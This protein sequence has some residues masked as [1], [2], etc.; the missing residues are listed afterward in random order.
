M[1]RFKAMGNI[2]ILVIL[3]SFNERENIAEMITHIQKQPLQP[4][5]LVVD[6]NSPDKTADIV[7]SLLNPTVHLIVRQNGKGGR[8]GAVRAGFEWALKQ[9]TKYDVIFEMDSDLSHNPDEIPLAMELIKPYVSDPVPTM[10]IGSRYL[11]DSSITGW[12]QHRRFF[13]RLANAWARF[14]LAKKVSDF[15]NGF[16]AYNSAAVKVILNHAPLNTGFIYLSECLS[17]IDCQGGRIL[18][19]ASH[20]Q[21]RKH[22]KSSADFTEVKN[23]FFGVLQVAKQMKKLKAQKKSLT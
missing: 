22:G 14:L 21:N 12:P 19:F 16:R 15:T 13:S 7:K 9:N 18:E 2:Q 6:D 1:L 11:P 4:H 23:A 5:V 3:P 10:V 17:L 20:W 8:G